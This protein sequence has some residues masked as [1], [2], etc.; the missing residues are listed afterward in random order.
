MNV[1]VVGGAGYIG[2]HCVRQ[3][4]AAGHRGCDVADLPVRMMLSCPG[5]RTVLVSIHVSLRQALDVVTVER[6]L[7]TLRIT[8]AHFRRCGLP[9]VRIAHGGC[10]TIAALA[11]DQAIAV[12]RVVAETLRD[13]PAAPPAPAFLKRSPAMKPSIPPDPLDGGRLVSATSTSP[14]GMTNRANSSSTP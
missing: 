1:L 5:L 3:A 4:L 12:R 13:S 9:L 2:S 8:D 10:T 7:Q 6:I 14:P 11:R